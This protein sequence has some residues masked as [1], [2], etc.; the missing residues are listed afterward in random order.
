M[1]RDIPDAGMTVL[2]LLLI[3]TWPLLSMRKL[4][5]VAPAAVEL[6]IAKRFVPPGDPFGVPTE[7][8]ANGE[9]V[10]TPTFRPELKSVFPRAKFDANKFVLDAVVAKKFVEVA[11][12]VVEFPTLR[13]ERVE[14]ENTMIPPPP[15][16]VMSLPVEVAH[17]DWLMFEAERHALFEAETKPDAEAERQPVPVAKKSCVVDAFW[18][19]RV[20][21][22]ALPIT[23][24]PMFS[25]VAKR[26]VEEAVVAKKFVEVAL[27]VVELPLM[28]RFAAPAPP[29]EE[30]KKV[31][32]DERERKVSRVAEP[33]PIAY[34]P[35]E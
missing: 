20:V 12:V 6:E 5:V 34:F 3:A 26:L 9:V 22:V 33:G 31:L 15:F 2:P 14:D 23:D 35:S 21:V 30:I 1:T 28:I 27:V 8:S 18:V 24:E 13:S 25:I 16:G 4:V 11:F 17:F 32:V 19:K 10:P 29:S 7:K